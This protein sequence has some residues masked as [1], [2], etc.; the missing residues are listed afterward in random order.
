[1]SKRVIHVLIT[2][3]LGASRIC[4]MSPFSLQIGTSYFHVNE[5]NKSII[6]RQSTQMS[7]TVPRRLSKVR[8]PPKQIRNLP[9]ES[10]G[11]A[12]G[13]DESDLNPQTHLPEAQESPSIAA[14]AD[15]VELR[16]GKEMSPGE[17]GTSTPTRSGPIRGL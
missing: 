8:N 10:G 4:R 15:Q 6:F 3:A 16:A 9:Q 14:V 2:L 7:S 17:L 12:N 13:R 1:M 5:S 11:L